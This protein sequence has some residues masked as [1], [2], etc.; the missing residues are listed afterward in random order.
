MDERSSLG[1]L[2]DST[3]PDV[4]D[5]R[6]LEWVAG[7]RAADE[8]GPRGARLE[9][10]SVPPCQARDRH[11]RPPLRRVARARGDR[12]P[13]EH[14]R[15]RRHGSDLASGARPSRARSVPS[16][17]ERVRRPRVRAHAPRLHVVFVQAPHRYENLASPA[18]VQLCRLRSGDHPRPRN[19]NGYEPALGARALC[20]GGGCRTDGRN[21]ESSRTPDARRNTP[22]TG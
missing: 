17:V 14:P 19:G 2:R 9:S 13:R 7:L 1:V 12:D 3:G 8:L 15:T 5:S 20:I 10:P 4:L 16:V 6:A 22:C 18:L 11:R 21:L